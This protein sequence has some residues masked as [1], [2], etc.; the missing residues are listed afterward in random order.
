MKTRIFAGLALLLLTLPGQAQNRPAASL[1]PDPNTY[2]IGP[3]DMLTITIWKEPTLSGNQLVRP[4]GMISLALVGDVQASGLTPVELSTS[5]AERLKKYL[6]N[7]T[8]TV[9]VVQINSKRVYLIGE[10]GKRGPLEMTPGMTVLQ[11][12]SSAGGVTDFANTKK[13]YILRRTPGGQLKI[14]VHYKEAV[15]G[16]S[17]QNLPLQPGDTIVIP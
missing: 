8:A 17:A 4:D 14:P 3:S 7:P 13:I 12:I 11:A 10:I 2:I 16:Y 6:Q 9:V 15:Q 1:I 5:I